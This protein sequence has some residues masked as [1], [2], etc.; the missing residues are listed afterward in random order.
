MSKHSLSQFLLIFTFFIALMSND[1]SS[2]ETIY[3]PRSTAKIDPHI[4]FILE[5]LNT[6]LREFPGKYQPVPSAAAYPQTRSINEAI[7]PYG[8][9]DL[10][11]T[12]STNERETKLIPIRIPLD[13]GL[14]GWRIAFVNDKNKDI[15]SQVKSL[16]DLKKFDAGQVHDWPDTEILQNNMLNVV[17]SSTYEAMF[18]MLAANRFDYS[19]RAIFEIWGELASHSSMPIFIDTHIVLHYPTAFYFFV[20]PRKPVFANDLKLGIERIITNGQF[21]KIFQK[22]QRDAIQKA[23]I[24]HRTVIELRNPLLDSRRLPLNRPELWFKP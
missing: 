13:K 12:M 17:S 24:K 5:I 21:E 2:S 1:A 20:S 23:D 3:Y 8:Q 22:Y 10:V 4:D 15:L 11:W 19:P 16:N 14:L 18:K 7:S 9:I 6:A